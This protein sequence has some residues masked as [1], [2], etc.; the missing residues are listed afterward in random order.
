MPTKC[1]PPESKHISDVHPNHCRTQI[2]IFVYKPSKP[3]GFFQFEITINVHDV[4]VSFSASFE[5]LCYSTIIINILILTVWGF[6]L[7]VRI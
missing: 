4:L 5:Y 1:Q 6:T 3:K 2:E 7:D